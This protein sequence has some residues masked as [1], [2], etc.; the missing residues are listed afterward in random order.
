MRAFLSEPRRYY[1]LQLPRSRKLWFRPSPTRCQPLRC[2]SS[3]RQLTLVCASTFRSSEGNC[4]GRHLLGGTRRT[5]T[6][7]DICWGRRSR[8]H[9]RPQCPSWPAIEAE[10]E[11]GGLARGFCNFHLDLCHRPQSGVGCTRGARFLSRSPPPAPAGND[12]S[13]DLHTAAVRTT[14][15]QTRFRA[16][17][18]LLPLAA[19]A[20]PP[21]AGT[22]E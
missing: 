3:P 2:P 12:R 5:T 14:P 6:V 4:C 9:R 16:A 17:P 20:F 7:E 1:L 13:R 18:V 8:S 10:D 15:P 21:E 22:P 11:N 19:E